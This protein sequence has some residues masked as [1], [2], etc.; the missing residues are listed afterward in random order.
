MDIEQTLPAKRRRWYP[1]VEANA[2][3][4][5]VLASAR[6]MAGLTQQEMGKVAGL[7]DRS[8]RY[9]E[10]RADPPSC[11]STWDKFRAAFKSRGVEVTFKPHPVIRFVGVGK[12]ADSQNICSRGS[13]A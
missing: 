5:R 1:P 12:A 9:W 7:T 8:I 6:V 2:H 11:W 3:C 4:G 13:F 10:V